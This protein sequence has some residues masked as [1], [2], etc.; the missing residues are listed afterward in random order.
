MKKLK[1]L[2][3]ACAIAFGGLSQAMGADWTAS[4][5]DAGEYYLYN[6]G[7]KKFLTSG[8][9]WGTHAALDYDGMR[10]T[11]APVDGGFT[12][13]TSVAFSGKYLGSNAYMDNGTAATWT[14]TSVDES[15]NVYTIKTNVENVDKYLTK[16]SDVNADLDEVQPTT[17]DG[18]WQLLTRE[19]LI[20]NL[21]NAT[22]ANPI[23]ASFYMTNP[24][25]RRG[26]PKSIEGTSLSDNGSFNASAEGLYAGGCTSYGQYHKTFDNYQSMTSVK[27]GKYRVSVKGFYRVDTGNEAIP[28]LYANNQKMNLIVKGNIGEDNATNA[29]IALVDDTYLVDGIDVIVTD[30]NL[31]V[32][33][34]SDANVGWCTWREFTLKYYGPT[35]SGEAIAIPEGGSIEANKWYYF[36][37]ISDGEFNIVAENVDNIVYTTDT[38]VLIEDQATITQKF[39]EGLNTLTQ[40]RYYFKSTSAQTFSAM[41]NVFTYTIGEAT[42]EGLYIQAGQ[43]ISIK[44]NNISTNNPNAEV[45]ASLNGILFN[46]KAITATSIENGFTFVVP[47]DVTPSTQYTLSIPAGIIGYEGEVYNE[48]QELTFTTTAIVDGTYFIKTSEGKYI[49]GGGNYATQAIADIYGRA[50]KVST[51]N[52]GITEFIFVDNNFH[53]FDAGNGTVF[54]DNNTNALWRIEKTEG[55]YHIVNAN[56]NGSLNYKLYINS[57]DGN[58]II[59]SNT[60]ATIWEFEKPENHLAAMKLNDDAQAT[61]A[62]TAAGI[63][64]ITTKAELEN[65]LASNYGITPITVTGGT[66]EAYQNGASGNASGTTPFDVFAPETVTGLKNGL[67]KLSVT[68]F[69]RATWFDDVYNAGGMRGLVYVYANDAKTQLQSITEYAA[70]EAY[71]EGWN[72]DIEKDGKHYPNSQGAAGQAFAKPQYVN[73]VYVYVTDGTI[74]FGIQNPLKFGNDGSRGNW[75]CYSNFTLTYYAPKATAEEKEALATAIENAETKPLGF[76]KDEYAPYTNI[77][78]AK[79]LSAAKA[80]DVN[81]ASGEAVVNATNAL[82]DAEWTPNASEMNAFYWEGYA[83]LEETD[84]TT[85]LGWT[86]RVDN[87]NTRI[88]ANPSGNTGLTAVNGYALMAKYD[89][90]YGDEAGY[91]MPLDAN[92]IY[93]ISFKYG[94]WNDYTSNVTLALKD[95]N[96]VSIPLTKTFEAGGN[97]AIHSESDPSLWYDLTGYFIT[98]EAGDYVLTLTKSDNKQKQICIGNLSMVKAEA[99]EFADGSVPYYAAGTYPSVKITRNLTAD[100]WAT[101]VYPFAVS[102]IDDIATFE[103]YDEATATVKIRKATASTANEPFLMRSKTTMAEI[104]LENVDVV[105]EAGTPVKTQGNASFVGTYNETEVAKED[106]FSKYALSNNTFYIIGANAATVAPYRAYFK[107]ANETSEA[108]SLNFEFDDNTATGIE[109]VNAETTSNGDI[110]N[111]NGQ[112][113]ATPMKGLY[114]MNGKKIV[115]K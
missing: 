19:Q 45:T 111:L 83:A 90:S 55:G 107:V 98:N 113:V 46:G 3:A 82:N 25:V 20:D 39:T 105:V 6:V 36:D 41:P 51:N 70:N 74:T 76:D 100:R 67:Y 40:N 2:L 95:P 50:I 106:G 27:N 35:I 108:R 101:A 44:Y 17:E 16:K 14:F 13:S 52:Q 48:A 112:K 102:G 57:S 78:A 75:V 32:G 42:A 85:P 66:G 33:V 4:K 73:D 68:A 22:S 53:L 54:T 9:W 18:Y 56:N 109:S 11:L 63:T 23:E 114:I 91:T 5:A 110:Y 86:N 26:W 29:T 104:V 79:A 62:A 69:Q 59:S 77:E 12:I 21:S 72:P 65:A 103:A 61:A 60:D 7:S 87:Y 37:V 58:R 92:S 89:T 93:K 34:K 80:I 88:I 84:K 47:N 97:T 15:S 38:S 8:N 1:V 99:I 94:G 49:S 96:G 24:K 43:T 71:T 30:G 10:V 64:G 115:I 31:R 28:Y 81:E